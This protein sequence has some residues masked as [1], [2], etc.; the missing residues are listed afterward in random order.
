MHKR[1]NSNYAERRGERK[2]SMR[3]KDLCESIGN[4][5]STPEKLVK[6]ISP[7]WMPCMNQITQHFASF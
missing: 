5:L 7:P 4:A 3:K 1:K 2:S 6:E